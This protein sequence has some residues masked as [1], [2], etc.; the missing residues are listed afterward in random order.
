MGWYPLLNFVG[1]SLKAVPY[2]IDNI[3]YIKS[4]HSYLFNTYFYEKAEN[5]LRFVII[6]LYIKI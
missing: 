2:K 6:K 4:L 5:M 3:V 1:N